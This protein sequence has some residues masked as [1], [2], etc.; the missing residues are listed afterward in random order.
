MTFQAT[1]PSIRL[2]A[3]MISR[4]RGK[5]SCIPPTRRGANMRKT[6]I[7]FR[8]S[9]R[10]GGVRRAASISAARAVMRG[11]SLRISARMCS[12][13][14]VMVEFPWLFCSWANPAAHP[15]PQNF[16]VGDSGYR[17]SPLWFRFRVK[18]TRGKTLR[19]ASSAGV[20]RHVVLF[21][22]LDDGGNPAL[23]GGT[24]QRRQLGG[25]AELDRLTPE[26]L[27][28]E[29]EVGG[30]DVDADGLDLLGDHVRLDLAIAPVVPEQQ[31]HRHLD[32][33]RRAQFRQ[34][35]LQAAIA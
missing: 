22:D 29:L 30:E 2:R 13:V 1:E 23:P 11:A 10:S 12:C 28:Q 16:R 32:F 24:E 33:A 35:E 34:A 14:L 5:S 20:A 26:T 17:C 4:P 25:I 18:R 9:R 21:V 31:D 19:G 15:L 8:L 3:L 27:G 7:D 6:P